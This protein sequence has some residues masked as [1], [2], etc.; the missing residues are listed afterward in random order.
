MKWK[1]WEFC[2][3]HKTLTVDQGKSL[4][5]FNERH[6]IIWLLVRVKCIIWWWRVQKLLT[7]GSPWGLHK[8]SLQILIA[9]SHVPVWGSVTVNPSFSYT[10]FPGL[11]YPPASL[12]RFYNKHLSSLAS[13]CA[14]GV[15]DIH[16]VGTC[17]SSLGY[18]KE[19]RFIPVKPLSHFSLNLQIQLL[20]LKKGLFPLRIPVSAG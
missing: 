15:L 18:Q 8:Y 4:P 16:P 6:F 10:W 17:S 20:A 19:D 2:L 14:G 7:T 12:A 13:T 1:P 11:P 3:K 5:T 9:W